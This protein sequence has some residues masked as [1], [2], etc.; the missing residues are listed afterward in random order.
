MSME[1]RRDS[2]SQYGDRSCTH[3]CNDTAEN[4]CVWI[5]GIPEREEQS[6]NISEMG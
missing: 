4:K 5:Y 2:R 6:D 1:G 3:T